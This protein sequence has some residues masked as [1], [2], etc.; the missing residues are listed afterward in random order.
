[1]HP[2]A[3]ACNSYYMTGDLISTA[4]AARMLGVT[5]VTITRWA[6]TGRLTPA[7]KLAGPRGA[8]LFHRAEVERL[9]RERSS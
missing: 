6:A 7:L 1:L 2:W 3:A 5:G 9:A 4:E 8:F